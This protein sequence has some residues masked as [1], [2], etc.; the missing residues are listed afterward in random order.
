MMKR[1][2]SVIDHKFDKKKYRLII[3]QI[4][5]AYKSLA[6]VYDIFYPSL[7]LKRNL[8]LQ[9]LHSFLQ[10][11]GVRDLLDCACGT[12]R[13]IIP[14]AKTGVY[15][16]IVGSDLSRA[17]LNIAKI[18]ATSLNILDSDIGDRKQGLGSGR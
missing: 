3:G 1:H 12:G 10:K 4:D 13:E 5:N 7:E 6:S 8:F 18:R 15:R 11:K 14:L 17:M 9:Q 16:N 2:T